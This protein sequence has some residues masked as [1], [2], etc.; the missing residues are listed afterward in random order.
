M[1]PDNGRFESLAEM[2]T[3]AREIKMAKLREAR[4]RVNPQYDPGR[5]QDPCLS[6]GEAVAIKGVYFRVKRIKADGSLGLKMMTAVE[7]A[8]LAERP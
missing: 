1:N 8:G 2:T 4:V 5:R 6:V 3:E 7:V